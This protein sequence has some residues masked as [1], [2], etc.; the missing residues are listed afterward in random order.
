MPE[1]I[2]L[3]VP[4]AYRDGSPDDELRYL[5]RSAERNALG[6]GTVFLGLAGPPPRWLRPRADLVCL[7]VGD[8]V[9]DCK[10]A[11]MARKLAAMFRAAAPAAECVWTCD[12]T[13]FLHPVSLAEFPLLRN[14]RTAGSLRAGKGLTRWQKRLLATLGAAPWMEGNFDAHA[15][16]RLPRESALAALEGANLARP[17]RT[18][19]TF[20]VASVWPGAQPPSAPQKD[21]KET[22]ECAL[23]GAATPLAK[24]FL[25][26]NDSA[27]TALL[28]R[29]REKF[30][31]PSRW[32]AA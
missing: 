13:A 9:R 1:A 2:P 15:P 14:P 29:L 6:L 12:D 10:D 11:N 19:G 32:E 5:L 17:P 25:G 3:C 27:F 23:D 8:P 24:P 18:V 28:P 30:P 20:L 21:W 22:A 7:H 31:T 26:Y 16:Q 4:L